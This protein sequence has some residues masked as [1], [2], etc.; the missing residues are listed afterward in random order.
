MI[1]TEEDKKFLKNTREAIE[2]A[3]YFKKM[4]AAVS[5]GIED[6]MLEN[7]EDEAFDMIIVFLNS[8]DKIMKVKNANEKHESEVEAIDEI[9]RDIPDICG[10]KCRDFIKHFSNL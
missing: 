1:V 9:M 7:E 6:N 3:A 4:A 8:L 10:E 2:R 5:V